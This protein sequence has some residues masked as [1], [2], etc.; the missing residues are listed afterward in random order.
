LLGAMFGLIAV[1]SWL[2]EQ[3]IKDLDVRRLPPRSVTVGHEARLTYEVVNHKARLPS[4][5]IELREAGL[6]ESAFV[7]RVPPAGT[8]STRSAQRFVQR[9]IYPLGTLTISTSFPFGLFYKERDVELP[10]EIV[11]WPRHDRV[12]R[13]PSPGAGRT[14]ARGQTVAGAPGSRGDYRGLRPYRPG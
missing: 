6:P 12:L 13:P 14:R 11:I 5:A 10:G 9:G 8:A 3:A 7:G 4:L 2:S 1:S